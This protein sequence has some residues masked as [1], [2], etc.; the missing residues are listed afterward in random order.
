MVY[1]GDGMFLHRK[2]TLNRWT[3]LLLL[4]V[5]AAALW[6]SLQQDQPSLTVAAQPKAP[7]EVI[8]DAGHGGFDGGAL[9]SNG[10]EEKGINLAISNRLADLLTLC[11]AEVYQ[12][13]TEDTALSPAG[14]TGSKKTAD[15]KARLALFHEHPEA[16][17]L[18]VHQNHF[19][20]SRYS[21][22]QM[23]YG[24]KNSESPLLAE[25]LQQRFYQLQP[26]NTRLIKKG[27]TSVYLLQKAENPMVLT[28]CGFLSN[29]A[30]AEKLADSAYQSQVAFTLLCGV[31]D[32]TALDT[33]AESSAV[34]H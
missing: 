13:R 1:G 27:P 17:V 26:D 20:N 10:L 6:C 14:M 19:T 15:I 3:A 8:V 32:Y 30:E 7:F 33:E 24:V 22:A 11:G 28:E 16:L 23:F 25:T 9:S 29:A 5:S 4:G 2:E 12:T 34:E 21:G 18:S 31:A